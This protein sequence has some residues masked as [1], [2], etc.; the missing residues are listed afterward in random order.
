MLKGNN[1]LRVEIKLYSLLSLYITSIELPITRESFGSTVSGIK[2]LGFNGGGGAAPRRTIDSNAPPGT[3]NDDAP[4]TDGQAVTGLPKWT[5]GGDA[6]MATATLPRRAG[7]RWPRGKQ[8][9]PA[10]A[11]GAV[12]SGDGGHTERGWLW[13]PSTTNF[14]DLVA[15]T[16]SFDLAALRSSFDDELSDPCLCHR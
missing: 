1:E 15:S 12:V 7:K 11:R 9:T 2:G 10:V 4:E 3:S 6:P 14:S 13:R 16:V 8:V 5:S